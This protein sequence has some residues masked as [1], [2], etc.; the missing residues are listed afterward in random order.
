MDLQTC[1]VSGIEPLVLPITGNSVS[2]G[3]YG[4]AKGIGLTIGDPPNFFSMR[5]ALNQNNTFVSN[6]NYCGSAQNLS[7]VAQQGGVYTP[8]P[9][10]NRTNTMAAWN[11]T[12]GRDVTDGEGSTRVFFNDRMD[13]GGHTIPGLPFFSVV[14]EDTDCEFEQY[15]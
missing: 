9:D 15:G 2:V 11:G 1:L 7:C 6:V 3:G 13:I 5:P 12:H 10:V 8:P 14:N 4:S